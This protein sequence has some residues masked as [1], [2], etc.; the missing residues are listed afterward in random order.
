MLAQVRAHASGGAIPACRNLAFGAR[1]GSSNWQRVFC[2]CRSRKSKRARGPETPAPVA[3]RPPLAI[4]PPAWAASSQPHMGAGAVMGMAL[5]HCYVQA[6][7][8][9]QLGGPRAQFG[10][11]AQSMSSAMKAKTWLHDCAVH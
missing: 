9:V 8:H 11:V 10:C 7:A 2:A 4:R 3:S 6:R 1:Q 5:P